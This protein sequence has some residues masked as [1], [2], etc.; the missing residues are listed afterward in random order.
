MD[1]SR[2]QFRQWLLAGIMT[3]VCFSGALWAA[4]AD[5]EWDYD[6]EFLVRLGQERLDFYAEMQRKAMD[7]KYASRTDELKI[8][9]AVYFF[10]IRKTQ[11]AERQLASFKPDN[12]KYTRVLY[13]RGTKY[14]E[15]GQYAQSDKA[16][17]E[18]F[19]LIPEAPNG[20]RAKKE[21][22]M[23]LQYY[24][25]VL[26]ELGRGNEA[27]ALIDKMPPDDN[28][29]ERELTYL[30]QLSKIEAEEN[31]LDDGKPVDGKVLNDATQELKSLF[32]IRDGISALAAIQVGRIQGILGNSRIKALK[33][34]KAEIAKIRYFADAI[35]AIKQFEDFVQ[36]MEE[37]NS[38]ATSPMP[39]LMYYKAIAI[40]GLA[41]VTAAK[42]DLKLAGKQLSKGAVV[43]FK[44]IQNDYKKSPFVKKLPKQFLLCEEVNEKWKLDV[45]LNLPKVDKSDLAAVFEK[46]DIILRDKKD[47]SAAASEYKAAID[48]N[49]KNPA[50]VNYVGKY[51]Q[52]LAML[53]KYDEGKKFIEQ[54]QATF[55]GDDARNGIGMAALMLGSYA[56]K[57]MR[58][59]PKG[60]P[61]PYKVKQEQIYFW[62]RDVFVDYAPGHPQAAAV[63]YDLGITKYNEGVAALKAA[64]EK[65]PAQQEA[66]I[67]GAVEI[68]KKVAP[69]F[70]RVATVFPLHEK[71][72]AALMK[73]GQIYNIT[74]QRDA[75]I[76]YFNRF[77]AA[78]DGT[79]SKDDLLTANY[80]I[81]ELNLRSN[82]P[83]EA[84]VAYQKVK[85]L[86]EPG[87]QYAGLK[88]AATF[89]EVAMAFLPD[90]VSRESNLLTSRIA[91]MEERRNKLTNGIYDLDAQI[92]AAEKSQKALPDQIKNVNEQ[93][94]ETKRVLTS[95]E[96]DYKA[97]AAAQAKAEA[98][99]PDAPKTEQ[100]YYGIFI[101]G[102]ED[103]AHTNATTEAEAIA[104]RRKSLEDEQARLQADQGDIT[105]NLAALTKANDKMKADIT[106]SQAR[107]TEIEASFA[108]I[109]K[110]IKDAE[111]KR[112]EMQNTLSTSTDDDEIKK[113]RDELKKQIELVGKLQNDKID[114]V[115]N[116]AKQEIIN[117]QRE[118]QLKQGA[119]GDNEWQ[120]QLFKAEQAVI[121]LK[122]AGINSLLKSLDVRQAFNDEVKATLEKD[123]AARLKAND[124]IKKRGAEIAAAV[125][126]EAKKEQ[127]MLDN[128]SKLTAAGI[129]K[130]QEQ[131]VK[132]QSEIRE[133]ET[134]VKPLEAE[135]K[136]EKNEAV[137]GYR[138]YLRVYP[139]G[140]YF[141]ICTTDLAAA[142][143]DLENYSEAVQ[144]LNNL[145][146]GRVPECSDAPGNTKC[147]PQKTAYALFN[148]AKAQTKAR[149]QAE[150]SATYGRLMDSKHP[151]VKEAVAQMPLGNLF[152]I[153][154]QG[155]EVNAP[156][157]A[158]AACEIILSRV[159]ASKQAGSQLR[160]AQIDKCYI[161]AA[162]AAL[163]AKDAAKAKQ[164]VTQLLAANPKT[165]FL[166]DARFLE[167][168]AMVA[169]GDVNGGIG[170]LNQ[171]LR[172][173]NDSA[174]SN[175]IRCKIAQLYLA[176]GKPE[177]RN[178][179]INVYQS[180]IDFAKENAEMNSDWTTTPEARNNQEWVDT[181]FVEAAKLYKAAG[182]S[183]KLK[184]T[185]ILYHKLFPR[186]AKLSVIDGI[187]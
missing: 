32:F 94:E 158:L 143:V 82:R 152:F 168:E 1:T 17:K 114:I 148:L 71:G 106:K 127:A 138:D 87:G 153:A 69:Y 133:I 81:A 86:T 137:T 80:L 41:E 18:Y 25:T 174:I 43:Y 5:N 102:V 72:K 74:D 42:G 16:F 28:M 108:K 4:E 91:L 44:K 142:L 9:H 121:E 93:A 173:V 171:M 60:K 139:S 115:S 113:T 144:Q 11:D 156:A 116:A 79:L 8:A 20:K 30:K 38:K 169:Q 141:A 45:K 107:I 161:N 13:I 181:S 75:A 134:A 125:D 55:T 54:L 35:K 67:K 170:M 46:G 33:M 34:N 89:R 70:Q 63:A 68:M 88:Q 105:R 112:A 84:H 92:R 175:R 40:R 183:Q 166:Y 140:K 178:S 52:C 182:D 104:A 123:E 167:A 39:E 27:A 31:K 23:A 163:L 162:K 101:K 111:A 103:A 177:Y 186:G 53:D 160:P 21:F 130:C 73:L 26:K 2:H 109:E 64:K 147:D 184:D 136:K 50:V 187:N 24:N 131:K 95:F 96:L 159:N 179:A 129:K 122:L 157:A 77:I 145:V 126:A 165:A 37:G 15:I 85:S 76:E 132:M 185:K 3:V 49:M 7:A 124:A 51:M 83:K 97:K 150:A 120:V 57:R 29:G 117:C 58:E 90:M 66:A 65:A 164:M 62:A 47:Y 99:K 56:D 6:F 48:K 78:D 149:R 176:S 151:A 180:I 14:A 154:D 155:M 100:E 19:K 36:E 118:I 146:G 22:I 61:N 119:I 128:L 135:W 12:P 10:S 59:W 110:D 98:A 172:K